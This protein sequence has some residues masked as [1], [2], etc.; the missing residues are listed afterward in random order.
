GVP[1]DLWIAPWHSFDASTLRAL[2]DV[3]IRSLSDGF[4]LYPYRDPGGMLWVPQQLW[5]FRRMPFG[6]WTVC[7]HAN[8]WSVTDVAQ[9][10]SD[11]R[12]YAA[13]ITDWT[14]VISLYGKRRRSVRD[15]LFSA[16]YPT[17]LRRRK[18]LAAKRSQRP[19]DTPVAQEL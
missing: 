9:F 6:L 14:S 4:A 1:P 10:R 16:I 2:R 8:H 11:L 3:G 7:A 13:A 18:R 15:R 12:D 5:K 19:S 17:L